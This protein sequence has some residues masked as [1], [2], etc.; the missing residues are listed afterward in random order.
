[1]RNNRAEFNAFF[2][3]SDFFIMMSGAYGELQFS[4]QAFVARFAIFSKALRYPPA[5]R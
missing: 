1:M 3:I 2:M 4:R 5:V